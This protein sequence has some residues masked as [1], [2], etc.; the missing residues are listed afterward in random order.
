MCFSNNTNR[1]VVRELPYFT[2]SHPKT[3]S[4]P[5]GKPFA[6]VWLTLFTL[7]FSIIMRVNP[8]H[9]TCW[10]SANNQESPELL[11]NVIMQSFKQLIIIVGSLLFF[12][13]SILLVMKKS[14]ISTPYFIFFSLHLVLKTSW[15]FIDF[16]PSLPDKIAKKV[17]SKV[18]F[19]KWTVKSNIP[20]ILI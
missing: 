13:P 12:Y 18:D 10:H 14:I 16:F 3:I 2:S 6:A 20:F 15:T 5:S 4:A 9:H 1:V 8:C 7:T 17:E 11:H 19:S